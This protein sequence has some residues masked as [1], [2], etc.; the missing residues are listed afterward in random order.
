MW[1]FPVAVDGDQADIL[2]REEV[3][4][5][6]AGYRTGADIGWSAHY[7]VGLET[8]HHFLNHRPN[9]W[10][11]PCALWGSVQHALSPHRGH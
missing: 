3:T 7:D 8:N 1:A 2:G 9:G 5:P 11:V 4:V 6:S 10:S